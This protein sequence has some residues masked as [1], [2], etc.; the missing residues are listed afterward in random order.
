MPSNSMHFFCFAAAVFPPQFRLCEFT[1]RARGSWKLFFCLFLRGNCGA[2]I[3]NFSSYLKDLL[4]YAMYMYLFPC[5]K[6]SP[7]P[8]PPPLFDHQ[9]PTQLT[10]SQRN[11]S[12]A[13]EKWIFCHFF[14][15]RLTRATTETLDEKKEE[16]GCCCSSD[17]S[18]LKHF[19]LK[20]I[21]YK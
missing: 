8:P 20:L 1:D 7:P 19:S 10:H 16:V 17:F 15:H 5:V 4:Y 9:L 6:L 3:V 18:L 21:G 12:H 11:A 2:P 13:E 14:S